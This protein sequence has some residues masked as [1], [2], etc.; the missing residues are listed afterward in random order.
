MRFASHFLV[1]L[2]AQQ[3]TAAAVLAADKLS[4]TQLQ[5]LVDSPNLLPENSLFHS[6]VTDA[7][8]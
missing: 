2:A 4:E 3:A 8:G 6:F 5:Y 7:S 1:L